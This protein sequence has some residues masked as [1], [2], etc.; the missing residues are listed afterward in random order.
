MATV[1]A[2]TKLPTILPADEKHVDLATVKEMIEDKERSMTLL[3]FTLTNKCFQLPIM[4][5]DENSLTSR[6]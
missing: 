4:P 3:F 6:T 1:S 2:N 5:L